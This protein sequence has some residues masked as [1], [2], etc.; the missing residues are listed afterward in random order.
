MTQPLPTFCHVITRFSSCVSSLLWILTLTAR[1]CTSPLHAISPSIT[2][3]F[4]CP[5]LDSTPASLCRSI[6]S[7]RSR[8]TFKNL[9]SYSFFIAIVVPLFFSHL[10]WLSFLGSVVMRTSLSLSLSLPVIFLCGSN[11]KKKETAL[12]HNWHNALPVI[13]SSSVTICWHLLKTN[14]IFIHD[15]IKSKPWACCAGSIFTVNKKTKTNGEDLQI[16]AICCS[17]SE[18]RFDSLTH[19]KLWSPGSQFEALKKNQKLNVTFFS[20]KHQNTVDLWQQQ[21]STAAG[22]S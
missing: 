1:N 11:Q 13:C 18:N 10:T 16:S 21:H 6:S 2:A 20:F 5:H 8:I 19:F 3:S 9:P 15:V 22:F 4:I 14:K 17:F 7:L 12:K